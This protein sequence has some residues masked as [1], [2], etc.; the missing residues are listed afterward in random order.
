MILKFSE[1]DIED[2]QDQAERYPVTEESI[3]HGKKFP[4]IIGWA[5]GIM[6]S[7]AVWI[8]FWAWLIIRFWVRP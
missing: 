7:V 6:L 2:L 5:F 3:K 8:Y 1:H 4:T